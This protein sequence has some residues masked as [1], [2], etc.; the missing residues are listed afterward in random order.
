MDC[1]ALNLYGFLAAVVLRLGP[2]GP[3]QAPAGHR[4]A[5]GPG[6]L[7]C[8]ALGRLARNSAGAAF[9]RRA[10]QHRPYLGAVGAQAGAG[11]I[12]PGWHQCRDRTV[13]QAVGQGTGATAGQRGQP[14]S[15]RHAGIRGDA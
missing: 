10:R 2:C 15:D 4:P 9:S 1:L 11:A 13:G 3:G 14:W 12:Y 5:T 7:Q 8:K 6:Q